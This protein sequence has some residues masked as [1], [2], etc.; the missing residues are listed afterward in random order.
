MW[1]QRPLFQVGSG[2][3]QSPVMVI[4]QLQR[5]EAQGC[6]MCE[7]RL[8]RQVGAKAEPEVVKENSI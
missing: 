8:L 4:Y 2:A 3:L 7:S 1:Q 5:L 6:P